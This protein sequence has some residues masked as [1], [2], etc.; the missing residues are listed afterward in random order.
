MSREI[1]GEVKKKHLAEGWPISQD[2]LRGLIAHQNHN[3]T[4][5]FAGSNGH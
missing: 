5:A 4:V 1:F 3:R 2:R